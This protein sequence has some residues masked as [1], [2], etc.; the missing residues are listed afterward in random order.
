MS[1]PAITGWSSSEFIMFLPESRLLT[2]IPRPSIVGAIPQTS[3]A[4]ARIPGMCLSSSTMLAGRW[5][6]TGLGDILAEDDQPLDPA[7]SVS[8]TRSRRP[9]E[10]QK[11]PSTPRIGIDKP[12]S[13]RNVRIGRVNRLRQAKVTH[14]LSIARQGT[15]DR[16][17]SSRSAGSMDSDCR[18]IAIISLD[19]GPNSDA[20]WRSV[21]PSAAGPRRSAVSVACSRPVCERIWNPRQAWSAPRMQPRT[22]R[23]SAFGSTFASHSCLSCPNVRSGTLPARA[24]LDNGGGGGDG[25]DGR[26]GGVGGPAVLTG[27]R[28]PGPGPVRDKGRA[29]R[30]ARALEPGSWTMLPCRGGPPPDPGGPVPGH[31]LVPIVGMR[32]PPGPAGG[33]AAVALR[34]SAAGVSASTA[35]EGAPTGG[36]VRAE[37]A[38]RGGRAAAAA[39][40]S[41]SLA[42]PAIVT[43]ALAWLASRTRADIGTR[44]ADRDAARSP[45]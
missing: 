30:R 45:A 5:L 23:C 28:P 11:S 13:A 24:S 10:R 33:A 43:L 1:W 44:L 29:G 40:A 17:L 26:P 14:H 32:G 7:Q 16:H 42:R 19:S 3:G 15:T 31:R 39:S 35:T 41:P 27:G 22:R 18:L 37:P 2:S 8:P 6:K 25:R 21:S 36:D 9:L 4:I 38:G 20:S 12:T 34:P